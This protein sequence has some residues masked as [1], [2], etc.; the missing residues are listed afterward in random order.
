MRAAMLVGRKRKDPSAGEDS[1]L[2]DKENEGTSGSV[3]TRASK[4]LRPAARTQQ[5]VVDIM[6]STAERQEK[7]QENQQKY[8][9]ALL[10]QNESLLAQHKEA[11]TS[12]NA[13]QAAL[14]TLLREGLL[15]P[16]S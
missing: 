8:Q 4:R 14:L 12:Y 1:E 9:D 16:K 3:Q 2:T 15:G 13:N 10:K 11:T 6:R 7:H 5:E